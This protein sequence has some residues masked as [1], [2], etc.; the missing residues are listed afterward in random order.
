[1]IKAGAQRV[2]SEL[3]LAIVCPDT[4]PRNTGIAGEDDHED[5]G[6]GAG[7][8]MNAIQA[9]WN[10]FYNMYDYIVDELPE[11]I[12]SN[13][14]VKKKCSISGHS[15]GGHGALTIALKNPKKYISVSA[16]AP[17]C[18]PI[19]SP[20]CDRVFKPFLGDDESAWEQYDATVLVGKAE[21][22]QAIFIDQGEADEYL[23]ER[24]KPA[25]L[26]KACEQANY[27]LTLRTHHGY[28]H[29]YYFVASFIE[30]HLR[31]HHKALSGENEAVYY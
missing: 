20:W 5:F 7:F 29:S 23:T 19:D 25:A 4:S 6:T 26:Q 22:K 1:M 16:L 15:M 27:P 10:E 8:Y 17:V 14:P 3:G 18:N 11:L 28:G 12:K 30:D 21:E 9:P 24:L 2:A 31:Y 13:F